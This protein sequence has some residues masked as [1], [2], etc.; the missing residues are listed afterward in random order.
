MEPRLTRLAKNEAVF[1]E[2]NERISEI[3]QELAPGAGNAELID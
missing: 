1:R 3:S 2:V